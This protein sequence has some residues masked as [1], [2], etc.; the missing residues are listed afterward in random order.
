MSLVDIISCLK[1]IPFN[2]DLEGNSGRLFNKLIIFLILSL[3]ITFKAIES[4]IV[5]ISLLLQNNLIPLLMYLY[6]FKLVKLHTDGSIN[7]LWGIES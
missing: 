6:N 7:Q 5:I 3:P 1:L 4:D 2:V